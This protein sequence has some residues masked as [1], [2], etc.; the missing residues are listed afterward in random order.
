[1]SFSLTIKKDVCGQLRE[2]EKAPNDAHAGSSA[3][4][5]GQYIYVTK[6]HGHGRIFSLTPVEHFG[7]RQDGVFCFYP[8][9]AVPK[10]NS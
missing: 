6:L 9:G 5:V 7:P 4:T 2:R 3:N 10:Q 8:N 1:M